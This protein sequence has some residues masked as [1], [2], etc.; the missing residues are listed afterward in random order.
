[1][2]SR[3]VTRPEDVFCNETETVTRS[4]VHNLTRSNSEDYDR[5]INYED[6]GNLFKKISTMLFGNGRYEVP[7]RTFFTISGELLK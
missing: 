2:S 3:T 4:P 6:S 1:M 7:K 5:D